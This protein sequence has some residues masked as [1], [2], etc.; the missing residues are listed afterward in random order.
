MNGVD[1]FSAHHCL[2]EARKSSPYE[3]GLGWTVQLDREPFVGQA[4]LAREKERGPSRALR[5]PRHRLGRARRRSSRATA[6]RRRSPRAPGA[7]GVPVYDADERRSARRPA[8]PGRRRSRRTWRWPRCPPRTR[9]PARAS[10]IEVTV[11]YRR[12]T[13]AADGR[14]AAVL[15]SPRE[16]GRDGQADTTRSSSAAATTASSAPPTWR[17][18]GARCWCSSGATCS[19]ARRSA[20]SSIPGFHFS[21]CSYV[22]S[23]FRPSII[24][25]LE[26]ARHG[27]EIIPLE[28]SFPPLPTAIRLCRWADP[29][30]TR[31][32]IARFSARDAE[33][34][35]EFGLAM[36]K[37]A[38]FAQAIIDAPAPDPTSLDPPELAKLLRLGNET[39]ARR[40]R[41]A[42]PEPQAAD[43]ERGRLPRPVVRV[44]RAQGA[45]VGQRHHRH[46]PRRALAGHRLRAAAPL[47]GRDRRRVPLLGLR[48]GRH[49]RDQPGLRARRARASAPRSAPRRPSSACSIENGRAAGVVLENGDE[50]RAKTV[51]SG[52]DPHRT[53]LGLVGREHLDDEFVTADRALQAARQLGQGQPGR[54]PAAR[55]HRPAAAT[56]APARRH[57]HR[58]EHRL[59]RARLRRGEVRRLLGAPL[60]Q[61]RHPLAAST[62]ASR[63]RAST[64]S[65]ASC[66]T[67]RTTSRRAP[68]TGPSERE[69]FGDAVVDTL[70]EYCP[71]LKESI[72]YR[73]V[74]TPWDLEQEFGLTEGNIFHGE[75]SLE[76]LALPA[77]GRGLGALP[78]ADRQPLDVRLG[79]ASGRRH[80]GRAGRARRRTPC[81]RSGEL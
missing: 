12:H 53:F 55:V 42:G 11:E 68:S 65:R 56:A 29:E 33:I 27:L 40:R 15:R 5:R 54:R 38:R 48:E 69:A 58:A 51:V 9:R 47:H 49:R 6:C 78:D 57:R 39:A 13:V 36:T 71:G 45:D 37:M 23:L 4:A 52:C 64:S 70:A 43:D 81:S 75:L 76:Q 67:R 66:S 18:R 1:Y 34:Y 35:P 59:P 50:I 80:H 20:R 10:A 63:R 24:R 61:R 28:C 46:L 2:I 32:E 7:T 16:R 22:V 44:R 14:Q 62:R 21:V 73:Q 30:R 25:E 77:P 8:A 26:L 31:R 41:P 74:L 72:L 60:P 79:H 17:R 3:I 19:A